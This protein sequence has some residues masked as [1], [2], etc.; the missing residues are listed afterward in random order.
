MLRLASLRAGLSVDFM[1][2]QSF[3][4]LSEHALV[5]VNDTV[6]QNVRVIN[7]RAGVQV[8]LSGEELVTFTI[9][10]EMDVLSPPTNIVDRF[11]DALR[12]AVP[13]HHAHLA[14]DLLNQT[15]R[16]QG[17]D[18]LLLTLVSAIEALVVPTKVSDSER[19]LIALLTQQVEKSEV[20]RDPERRAALASRVRGLRNDSI[21]AGAKR[22][23]Q[24]LEPREY[25]G[26]TATKFFD[27]VYDLR[28]RLSHGDGPSWR[29]VEDIVSELRRFTLDLIELDFT[30]PTW[31]DGT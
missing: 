11:A 29:D 10:A 6:P 3:S 12:D 21:R 19:E 20:V 4:A 9:S 17:S 31:T 25:G 22:L 18:S 30:S 2:R 23:I 8:H 27:R 7:E 26:T 1:E 16:A 15:S 5:A 14:F 24:R 13:S 28:S